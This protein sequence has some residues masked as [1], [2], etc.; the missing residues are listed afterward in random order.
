MKRVL[1]A[2]LGGALLAGA[3]AA[4]ASDA[5]DQ[6]QQRI[7][8]VNRQVSPSVVHIE[9]A[10]R[11]NNRGKIV[12]GSGFLTDP[13]G[14]VLT[15]WHVVDRARKVS[16]IVPGRTGRYLAE[17]VGSD[18]QTDLAVL[19]LEPRDGDEPFPVPILGDSDTLSVGE[20]VLAIGNPY[21][22]E[23]TVSLGIVSGKGRDLKSSQILNAFIQT[24]AM[25]DQGSSGGPLLNLRGEVVG[26]NSRG[27]GRGIGFTIPINTA[28]RVTSDL[29][30]EGRIA[31]AYLGVTIQPL[32]REL[33]AYWNIPDTH[34]AVVG[35]VSRGSPA[36]AAGLAVG[37]IIT[38]LDD[39][40][41]KAE[42]DEDLGRF[43]RK[44]ARMPVG[45][46]VELELLRGGKSRVV[47]AELSRQ[48]K[49]VP[50]EEETD[51]GFTVQELTE[52]LYRRNRLDRRDG[53]LVSFV[54]RGSEAAE[55]AM[56]KGDMIVEL[57]GRPIRRIEDFRLVLDEVPK[58]QPFLVRALRGHDTRFMLISPGDG[59][60][61]ASPE[62]QAPPSGS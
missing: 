38:R 2:A 52:E 43:Q 57:Q 33:A 44:V 49:V 32:D 26:V 21:G 18:K 27:Q 25:I 51:F 40:A 24:D 3:G 15:N 10:I 35:S 39:Q 47:L 23:G 50:D 8:E 1:L 58:G 41:V 54:E 16:V 4:T 56:A 59:D 42:K 36:E 37:D 62:P 28:K 12:T 11:A 48:P 29:L 31:R 45:Q 5:L 30:G 7:I 17:V 55:A 61:Q 9:A 14:V 60:L 6:L 53:V 13:A 22:L 20:W 46:S 19:R 34:G